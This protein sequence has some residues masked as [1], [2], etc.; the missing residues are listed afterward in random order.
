MVI[1]QIE[2]IGH[3]LAE[4]SACAEAGHD[5]DQPRAP[6]GQDLQRADRPARGA[7]TGHRLPQ[8][9]ALLRV[10]GAQ[11]AGSEKVV[12]R[13]IRVVDLVEAAGRAR[14]HD[15]ARFGLQRLAQPPSLIGVGHVPEQHV[16]VLGQQ[17]EPL[18]LLVREVQQRPEATIGQ[19]PIVADGSQLF[20]GAM[21]VGCVVSAR[22]L[23]RQVGQTLQPEFPGGGDVVALLREHDREEARRQRG[24]P[25]QLGRD[26]QEHGRLPAATRADHELVGV[27]GSGTVAQDVDEQL[28]L[29]RSHAVRRHEL[30]VGEEAGVEL[31]SGRGHPSCS[32]RIRTPRDGDE[33]PLVPGAPPILEEARDESVAVAV[34][35]QIPVVF[36][37][38]KHV[39]DR[40]QFL[41]RCPGAELLLIAID[42]ATPQHA[43][44]DCG[45]GQEGERGA[46]MVGA[47][48][49]LQT[50]LVVV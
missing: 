9:G 33:V 16:Q 43:A 29:C 1:D 36:E 21:Q 39:V 32:L 2:E 14:E 37:H 48:D 18:V 5:R 13:S 28:E 23:R 24:I 8:H 31:A 3:E 40:H 47:E 49:Q 41:A 35:L 26:A 42:G 6:A 12:Q 45:L 44:I 27:R 15:D 38:A 7:A 34:G 25:V 46:I 10:E 17:Q 20:D 11:R 30:V 22:R 4:R 19:R 50:V